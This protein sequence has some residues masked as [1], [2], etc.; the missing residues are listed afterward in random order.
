MAASPISLPALAI[1]AITTFVC[2]LTFL[3]P[4]RSS[5]TPQRRQ[6]SEK[7]SF[8]S[9][10]T[11]SNDQSLALPELIKR[12]QSRLPRESSSTRLVLVQS[13]TEPSFIQ[14]I[15]MRS[16]A[17]CRSNVYDQNKELFDSGMTEAWE[18]AIIKYVLGQL[19]SCAGKV[20]VDVGAN[21]GLF[22]MYSAAFGCRIIAF[23][24][25]PKYFRHLE[26][27]T[28]ANGVQGRAKLHNAACSDSNTQM[29]YDGWSLQP[30]AQ[31]DEA[32]GLV[33]VPVMRLDS[34]VTQ[35]VVLL[36]TDCEGHDHFAIRS[37][38]DLVKKKRIQTIL[39]EF[40]PTL[41]AKGRDEA[42]EFMSWILGLGYRA[43]DLAPW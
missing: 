41:F 40:Y 43:F 42:I 11:P 38:G 36:K 35:D 12:F 6:L 18:F 9:P 28:Y 10:N 5:P 20:V 22:S 16:C 1:I 30:L 34:V 33:V 39:Y 23:E 13:A 3:A 8:E 29:V 37:G 7:S 21:V 17:L 15:E 4:F 24:P 31:A 26:I 2:A 25:N 14:S 27:S 19:T 32:K